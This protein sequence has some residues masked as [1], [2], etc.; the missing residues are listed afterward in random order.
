M[1]SAYS[2]LYIDDAAC[3]LGEYLDYMVNDLKYGIDEAFE[4]FAHSEIGCSFEKGNPSYVAGISG[5]EM[6]RKVIFSLN[7]YWENNDTTMSID[8]SKEYWTGW[9]LAQYQWEKNISFTVLLDGKISASK[10]RDLYI[11]HE[12]DFSKF[13]ETVDVLLQREH[14]QSSLKRIRKY[15]GLTQSE[16]SKKSGVSLRMIQLYEQGQNDISHAQTKVV[17]LLA[18]ALGCEINDLL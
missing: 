4:M 5:V 7:G 10:V 12:A 11:L 1:M 9:A 17:S 16:L 14:K 13:V 8:R 3:N 15:Y 6:A 2:E 18:N